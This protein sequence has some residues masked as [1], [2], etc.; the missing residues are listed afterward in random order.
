MILHHEAR[1]ARGTILT[2]RALAITAVDHG[3]R[4]QFVGDIAIGFAYEILGAIMLVSFGWLVTLNARVYAAFKVFVLLVWAII[5]VVLPLGVVLMYLQTRQ[6]GVAILA[7]LVSALP[8]VL[9]LRVGLPA[10]R[11]AFP[12]HLPRSRYHG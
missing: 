9:W 8:A 2:L 1:S 11:A 4:M 10:L 6:F 3:S 5:A 12:R 7:G